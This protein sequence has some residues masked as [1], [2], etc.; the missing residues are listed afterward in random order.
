MYKEEEINFEY[1][2]IRKLTSK[3]TGEEIKLKSFVEVLFNNGFS[4]TGF[5]TQMS[6]KSLI[7][8]TSIK[9]T[10]AGIETTKNLALLR[11]VKSIESIDI[12]EYGYEEYEEGT[13]EPNWKTYSTYMGPVPLKTH[14]GRE[15]SEKES[16]LIKATKNRL[17][18][19]YRN[20]TPIECIIDYVEKN[21][22]WKRKPWD[23]AQD[24]YNDIIC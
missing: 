22:F 18:S 11:D 10:P 8:E 12:E 13:I 7:I 17:K 3:E 15:L 6:R 2:N 23:L 4:V 24:Y 14:D 1:E 20:S 21:D 19:F 16:I 5:I 9:Y